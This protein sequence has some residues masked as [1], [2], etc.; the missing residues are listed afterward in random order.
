MEGWLKA[1]IRKRDKDIEMELKR[2]NLAYGEEADIIRE[3]VRWVLFHKN[4]S[5][6]PIS[7]PLFTEIDSYLP[8]IAPDIPKNVESL[9]NDLINF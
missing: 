9:L 4:R 8:E 1:R 6:M 7:K 3:G 5:E 2:L